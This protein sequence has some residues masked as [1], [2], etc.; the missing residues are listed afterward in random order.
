MTSSLFSVTCMLF[1]LCGYAHRLLFCADS[2]HVLLLGS[3]LAGVLSAAE[4]P[5]AE[6]LTMLELE[7][8]PEPEPDPETEMELEL[9]MEQ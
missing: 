1:P 8:E 9:E 2:E 7:P 4:L 6:L 5:R 3:W